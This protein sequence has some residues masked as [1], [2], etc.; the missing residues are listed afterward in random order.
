MTRRLLSRFLWTAAVAVALAL[1]AQSQAKPPDLPVNIEHTVT[2]EVLPDSEW[3]GKASLPGD[4]VVSPSWFSFPFIFPASDVSM[5]EPA[6]PDAVSTPMAV[7]LLAHLPPVERRQ[8]AS[9][10]L[11]GVHPLLTLVPTDQLVDMGCDHPPC[12]AKPPEG[13]VHGSIEIGIG[14]DMQGRPTYKFHVIEF[15]DK[16]TVY[17]NDTMQG[18]V[19]ALIRAL[20]QDS[21]GAAEESSH[22]LATKP[23]AEPM[24]PYLRLPMPC[25]GWPLLPEEPNVLGGLELLQP[26]TSVGCLPGVDVM[27]SGLMKSCHLSLEAGRLDHSA[28]LVQQAYALD[29]QRVKADPVLANLHELANLKIQHK[30]CCEDCPGCSDCPCCQQP[31]TATKPLKI[32]ILGGGLVVPALPAIDPHTAQ[33]LEDV[34][35]AAGEEQEVHVFQKA[36]AKPY[37]ETNNCPAGTAKGE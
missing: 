24:C 19:E 15:S 1:A 20:K 13:I 5:N 32:V 28:D 37:R 29:P 11:F 36:I 18:C 14:F 22:D 21:S 8:F 16:G 30:G 6:P 10:L 17:T 27:V 9:V 2:P 26:G 23:Q 4:R 3:D 35:K 12:A 31:K 33:T 25:P 34:L 7:P